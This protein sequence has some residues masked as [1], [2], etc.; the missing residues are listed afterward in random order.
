MTPITPPAMLG[1]MGGGELGRYVVMAA[2]TMGYR[3]TVLEPDPDSPAG[4]VADVH[5]VA[6]YDDPA[7]LE[8]LA[9][10]CAVVTTEFENAPVTALEHV[11]ARTRVHPSPAAIAVCQD[12]IAE[13]RF[14]ASIGVP[15]SPWRPVTSAAELEAATDLEYPAILKTAR[16]GDDGTRQVV[17]DRH[18][19]AEVAWRRLGEVPCVLEQ[20]LSLDRE[21]SVVL[22]RGHDGSVACFPVGESRHVNGILDTTVAPAD[23]PGDGQAQAA[24]LCGYIAE[25]LQ[26]VGVLGVEMFVV[27]SDVFVNELAPCPHNSGHYTLDACTTSQFEQQVRTI[28]GLGLG[29]PSLTVASV[30]TVNLLGELWVLGEPDWSAALTNPGAHLHLYGKA[31]ARTGRKMGHLTVTSTNPTGSGSLARRLRQQAASSHQR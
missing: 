9:A 31:E 6:A 16:L 30:G 14:L 24:E 28:C 1:I 20:R 27:G 19:D 11:A 15:V 25:Q 29:D 2:R 5:L 10:T 13:K 23:L 26:Y 18:D 22:A 3:T 17:C 12:R 21:L 8:Q 7:A 4:K